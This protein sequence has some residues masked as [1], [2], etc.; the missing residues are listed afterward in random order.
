MGS[1][2]EMAELQAATA[3]S[4]KNTT[5]INWPNAT[6]PKANGRLTNIRPGPSLGFRPAANTIGNNARP[7]TRETKV[8]SKATPTTVPESDELFGI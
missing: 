2:K 6:L 3:T 4:R 8:S 7:A 1:S 5:P